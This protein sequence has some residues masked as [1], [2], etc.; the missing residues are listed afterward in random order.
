M[1]DSQFPLVVFHTRFTRKIS[2]ALPNIEFWHHIG[3]KYSGKCYPGLNYANCG[4]IMDVLALDGKYISVKCK[5]KHPVQS[6]VN[7]PLSQ[8]FPEKH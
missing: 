8:D 4:E 3:A 2:S 5:R 7:I 6:C 1:N